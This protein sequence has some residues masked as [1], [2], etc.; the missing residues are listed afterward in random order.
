MIK[1]VTLNTVLVSMYLGIP[2][3][4]SGMMGWVG[5]NIMQGVSGMKET[6]IK[7]A[8]QAGQKGLGA[9]RQIGRIVN[10]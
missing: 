8:T 3:V 7:T 9:A 10:R 5:Y 2:L 4:W 1:R 6:A